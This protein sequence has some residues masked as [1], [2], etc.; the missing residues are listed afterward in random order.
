M[1]ARQLELEKGDWECLGITA[2]SRTVG[3][4]RMGAEIEDGR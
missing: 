1:G 4:G 3:N 2:A